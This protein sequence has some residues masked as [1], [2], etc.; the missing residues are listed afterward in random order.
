MSEAGCVHWDPASSQPD[1]RF[2]SSRVSLWL[3][4]LFLLCFGYFLPLPD[5]DAGARLD[6]ALAIVQHGTIA[7]D[8]YRWN[9][10]DVSYFHGHY[11]SVT[12]PGQGLLGTPLCAAYKAVVGALAGQQRADSIGTRTTDGELLYF[13]LQY[14]E[15]ILTVAIPA[16]LLLLLFY[17]FLGHFSA[18]VVN[19]ALLTLA[20][21]L[22]TMIFPYGHVFYAHVPVAALLFAAFVLVHR[23]GHP[24]TLGSARRMRLID[25]PRVGALLAG[26]LLGTAVVFEY[27]AI[28][29]CVLI[30]AYALLSVPR[31]LV[32]YM[33]AGA[34]PN[35]LVVMAY[36]YLAYQNPF[37]TGYSAHSVSYKRE[38]SHGLLAALHVPPPISAI[39]GT[40]FSPYRGL[41]FLSPFLLL[42]FPGLLL[43]A[44]RGGRD[45]LPFLA[46][47]VVYF[48]AMAMYP[49]WYAG[50]AVGPRFLIPMLPFLA[51]PII[52]VLDRAASWSARLPIY[53][54]M[55][56]SSVGIWVE[57]LG[58]HYKYPVA[59]NHNPFFTFSLPH[60]M[61]DKLTPTFGLPLFGASSKASMLPLMVLLALW[62][63]TVWIRSNDKRRSGRVALVN[64]LHGDGL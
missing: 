17:W 52:F 51:V 21:G 23:L 47:P 27:P 13:L 58:I 35:L 40:S 28:I 16:T 26:W 20:L 53:G 18:S 19:R 34:L 57:S 38:L 56:A 60:V 5:A 14:L 59:G 4:G 62:T 12:A 37:I 9:T 55:L 11:Y 32:L 2:S 7:I 8:A 49:V 44:R 24:E 30:G 50:D 41:F 36:D 43:W 39:V 10:Q 29:I 3:A 25:H 54:L 48:F 42:A 46:I 61:Q 1:T 45:W 6:M 15:G 33:A 64:V 22:A 31:K 63:F